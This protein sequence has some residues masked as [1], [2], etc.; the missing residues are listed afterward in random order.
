MLATTRAQRRERCPCLNLRCTLACA[1]GCCP[2]CRRKVLDLICVAKLWSSSFPAGSARR[3]SPRFLDYS[4]KLC[5]V[6]IDP[7]PLRRKEPSVGLRLG[8]V[9][10]ACGQCFAMDA[11]RKH[12]CKPCDDLYGH[13]QDT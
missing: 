2:H 5:L 8:I 1:C 4:P 13:K 11:I 9:V 12:V 6:Q 7:V 3:S 10:C